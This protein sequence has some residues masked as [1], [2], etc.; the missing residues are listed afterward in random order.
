MRGADLA[1]KPIL[2]VNGWLET[3]KAFLGRIKP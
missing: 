2:V 1:V 3:V